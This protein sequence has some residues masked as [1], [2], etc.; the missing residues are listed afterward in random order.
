MSNDNVVNLEE[1]EGPKCSR[2]HCGGPADIV[3]VDGGIDVVC[4]H[5]T[6]QQTIYS[7]PEEDT[8]LFDAVQEYILALDSSRCAASHQQSVEKALTALRQV[9]LNAS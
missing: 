9:F 3:E 1:F 8:T 6:N 4:Q 7:P 2:P 5:C